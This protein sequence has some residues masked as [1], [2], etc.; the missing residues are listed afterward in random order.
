MLSKSHKLSLFYIVASILS[1][2]FVLIVITVQDYAYENTPKG[3]SFFIEVHHLENKSVLHK[4]L[5]DSY[6]HC[7]D[8][9]SNCLEIVRNQNLPPTVNPTIWAEANN[10]LESILKEFN[11]L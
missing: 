5:V 4:H 8:S 9:P 1:I 2:A 10:E 6:E 7:K 11:K 3:T